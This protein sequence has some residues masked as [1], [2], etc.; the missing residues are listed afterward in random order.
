MVKK[1]LHS[2]DDSFD[3]IVATI[4]ERPD[5]EDLQ[6]AEAMK[7][8]NSQEED[9]EKEKGQADFSSE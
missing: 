6:I 7:L 9:L 8:L 3:S 1:L 5:F 2:L 4:K